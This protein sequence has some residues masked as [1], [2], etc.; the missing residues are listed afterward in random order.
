MPMTVEEYGDY[1]KKHMDSCCVL[2]GCMYEDEGCP[3]VEGE[4]M[5]S[6]DTERGC[7]KCSVLHQKDADHV[8]LK[9]VE[10]LFTALDYLLEDDSDGYPDG[11]IMRVD[12]NELREILDSYDMG[13][14]ITDADHEFSSVFTLGYNTLRNQLDRGKDYVFC[15][16]VVDLFT[17]RC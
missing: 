17:C 5:Q 7:E 1:V 10:M 2:H 14:V 11:I 13:T 8:V 6:D 9:K 3:I 15:V 16:D 4:F 12:L